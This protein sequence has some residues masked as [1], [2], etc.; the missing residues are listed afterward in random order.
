M[1]IPCGTM[2]ICSSSKAETV[3]EGRGETVLGCFAFAAQQ[4]SGLGLLACQLR[5]PQHSPLT[6]PWSP[7]GCQ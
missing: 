4:G 7:Q 6:Q 2:Y 3:G 1:G 5:M